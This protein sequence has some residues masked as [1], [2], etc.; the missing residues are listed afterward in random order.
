MISIGAEID[1]CSSTSV[2]DA[3]TCSQDGSLPQ[4]ERYSF[5]RKE[6]QKL[7]AEQGLT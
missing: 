5:A 2:R 3:F 1:F 7:F 6:Q 4:L